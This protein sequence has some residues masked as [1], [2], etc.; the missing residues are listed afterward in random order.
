MSTYNLKGKFA[1]V[2][3]AGSGIGH[4]LAELLLHSGC[5]VVFADISL[6][7]AAAVTVSRY[8]LFNKKGPAALFHKTDVTDWAQLSDLWNTTLKIF[9]QIDI[10]ANVAGIYEPPSSNFWKLPGEAPESKD[11]PDA[12][13]GAYRTISTNYIAPI[14]LAQMAIDYWCQN[15]QVKGNYLAVASMAAYLHSMES[16]LYMSSKAGLVS[17]IKSLGELNDHLGIRISAVCPGVVITPLLETKFRDKLEEDGRYLTAHE[18]AGVILR[19]L[20]EPQWGRGSIVE[21]NKVITDKG[22]QIAVREVPLEALYPSVPS[23]G[24]L[25]ARITEGKRQLIT[26]LQDKGIETSFL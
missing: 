7:Y 12:S 11:K 5:N 23:F 9:G 13:P 24:G 1:I 2:T 26:H 4:A 15:S 19:V 17:F 8:P 3:G 21:T 14:R 16:P 20:K 10:V 18:C 22:S 6:R 25:G